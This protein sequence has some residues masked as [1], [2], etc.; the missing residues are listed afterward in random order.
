MRMKKFSSRMLR[1]CNEGEMRHERE[2][3]LKDKVSD[4]TEFSDAQ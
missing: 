1:M 2:L 3:F 4:R